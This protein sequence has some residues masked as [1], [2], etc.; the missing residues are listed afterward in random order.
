MVNHLESVSKYKKSPKGVLTVLYSKMKER[1]RLKGLPKMD[2]TLEEFHQMFLY[3]EYFLHLHNNWRT[4]NYQRDN[5]PSIDRINP[6]KGYTKDNIQ[7]MTWKE[8]RLKGDKENAAR[9]TTSLE[10]YDLEGNKIKEFDSIKEA[11]EVTGLNQGLIVM[12]CQGKRNHT[13]GFV[14][15]YRGDKFRKKGRIS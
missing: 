2:F 15:K 9:I 1:T 4:S 11:V 13:G 6:D 8:N 3:N 5:K 7:M 10:M 14:F 12:C